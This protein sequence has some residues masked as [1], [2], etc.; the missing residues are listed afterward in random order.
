MVDRKSNLLLRHGQN[1]L[2]SV[3]AKEKGEAEKMK[4]AQMM[5]HHVCT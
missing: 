1:M 3:G 5:L 2:M 4:I